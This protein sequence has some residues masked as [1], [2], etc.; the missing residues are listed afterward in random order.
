MGFNYDCGELPAAHTSISAPSASAA[1]GR[2]HPAPAPL[3]PARQLPPPPTHSAPQPPCCPLLPRLTTT[4]ASAPSAA[5]PRNWRSTGCWCRGPSSPSHPPAPRRPRSRGRPRSTCNTRLWSS[6]RQVRRLAGQTL[7]E[8]RAN[9]GPGG[10]RA[11]VCVWLTAP[12][13]GAHASRPQLP[14]QAGDVTC[15][16]AAACFTTLT[17]KE[18]D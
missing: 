13:Y 9:A 4:Q 2:P 11:P 1:V 5:R 6:P 7:V 14:V 15:A 12:G 10:V 16:C 8:G 17:A 3:R 18:I